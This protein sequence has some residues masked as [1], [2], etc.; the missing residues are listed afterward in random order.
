VP[1]IDVEWRDHNQLD[2]TP[3]RSGARFRCCGVRKKVSVPTGHGDL[4]AFARHA[5]AAM[6]WAPR[7]GRSELSG[8]ES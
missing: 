5:Y 6:G 7:T 8:A 1:L 3:I 4:S 2:K